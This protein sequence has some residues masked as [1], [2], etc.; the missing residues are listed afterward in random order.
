MESDNEDEL[1]EFILPLENIEI[2]QNINQNKNNLINIE[3]E[4]LFKEYQKK[5][6]ALVFIEESDNQKRK[7]YLKLKIEGKN[8][9]K[10]LSIK[11]KELEQNTLYEKILTVS[12]KEIINLVKSENLI[13]IRTPSFLKAKLNLSKKTN[14]VELIQKLKILI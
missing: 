6:L 5:N 2:I 1:I 7:V 9:S 3:I 11:D 14:L 4:D 13:D 12:K 10:G 8:I